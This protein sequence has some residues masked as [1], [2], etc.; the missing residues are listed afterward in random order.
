MGDKTVESTILTFKQYV[1]VMHRNAMASHD[2]LTL[3]GA[4]RELPAMMYWREWRDYVVVSF[5]NG[6][7]LTTRLWRSFDD[8]LQWRVLRTH[9]ALR[10]DNLTRSLRNGVYVSIERV[11]D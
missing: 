4:R 9:R 2:G 10:D 11:D 1:D 5:D 6:A 3:S 8:A 7:H